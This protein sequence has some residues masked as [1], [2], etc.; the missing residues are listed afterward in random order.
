MTTLY[1]ILFGAGLGI[2][3][4]LKGY[5]TKADES[6]DGVK[7]VKTAI[8][9]A[10]IGGI[11][12]VAGLTFESTEAQMESLTILGAFDVGVTAFVN[13]TWKWIKKRLG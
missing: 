11:A 2:A 5:F 8:I 6:L 4:S 12:G 9:G 7:I 13:K 1:S 3:Y 10:V